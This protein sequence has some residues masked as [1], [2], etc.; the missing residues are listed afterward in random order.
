M[1]KDPN[2]FDRADDLLLLD[3]ACYSN[4]YTNN[5]KAYE[6]KVV[7]FNPPQQIQW[8]E[9]DDDCINKAMPLPRVILAGR[10]EKWSGAFWG[11]LKLRFRSTV[12]MGADCSYLTTVNQMFYKTPDCK[13]VPYSHFNYPVPGCMRNYNGTQDF[14]TNDSGKFIT[15][16][17]YEGTD[18]CNPSESPGN[19]WT[20]AIETDRCY[21]LYEDAIPMS[22][23]WQIDETAKLVT[24]SSVRQ[25]S[26]AVTAPALWS[27]CVLL[28]AVTAAL[29]T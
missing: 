12:C 17:L 15:H 16:T 18:F 22:F 25:H 26:I 8:M 10:C 24:G 1:Y 19:T 5:T 29:A 6:L 9:Y 13:G 3:Q 20:Y 7:S 28:A 14:G 23:M 2:C 27:A 21:P 4:I 11:I